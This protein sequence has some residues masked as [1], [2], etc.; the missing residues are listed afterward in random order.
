MTVH[1]HS[2]SSSHFTVAKVSRRMRRS[3]LGSSMSVT[4]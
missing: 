2:T 1:D 3:S 4:E